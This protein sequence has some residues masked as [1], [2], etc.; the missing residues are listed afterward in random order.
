M[1]T[2][3]VLADLDRGVWPLTGSNGI[4]SVGSTPLAIAIDPFHVRDRATLVQLL[5]EIEQFITTDKRTLHSL[6]DEG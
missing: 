4:P 3:V 2:T 5:D 1:A 6:R